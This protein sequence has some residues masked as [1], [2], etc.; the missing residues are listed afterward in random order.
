MGT[1]AT[2]ADN[3]AKGTTLA[4]AAPDATAKVKVT[5][6]SGSEGGTAATKT[7]T[8][9]GGTTL[10]ETWGAKTGIPQVRGGHWLKD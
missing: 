2:V 6:S 4:L 7:Y 8:I 1:R 10:G 3:S 9:K 5:A